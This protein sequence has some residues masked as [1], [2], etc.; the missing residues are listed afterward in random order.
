MPSAWSLAFGGAWAT[1]W[2]AGA[3]PET[4]VE[5]LAS[6]GGSSGLG[7]VHISARDFE[8]AERAMAE[9][10]AGARL[11]EPQP[12]VAPVDP[13]P[14]PMAAPGPPDSNESVAPGGDA[15]AAVARIAGVIDAARELAGAV[16][17]Q[18]R[19]EARQ[20][21]EEQARKRCLYYAALM[22][23]IAADDD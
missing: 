12:H 8:D 10:L 3:A 15:A 22:T 7:I 4:P 19:E 20:H 11:D 2:S 5:T 13:A 18:A 17:D 1:A 14:S 16:I 23:A 9:A 6:S 21:E